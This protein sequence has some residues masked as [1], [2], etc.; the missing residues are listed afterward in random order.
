MKD[1]NL[2]SDKRR[3]PWPWIR[4]YGMEKYKL[5]NSTKILHELAL[6]WTEMTIAEILEEGFSK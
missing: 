4:K 6:R 1:L 2:P 3:K 5:F